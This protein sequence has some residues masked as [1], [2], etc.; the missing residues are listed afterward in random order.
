V[1]LRTSL[2]HDERKHV[3][4]DEGADRST[5]VAAGY[6]AVKRTAD[7]GSGNEVAR[8]LRRCGCWRG[9]SEHGKQQSSAQEAPGRL[10]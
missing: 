9:D 3:V 5:G 8:Y 1:P 7:A 2:E 4:G 6:D 10:E